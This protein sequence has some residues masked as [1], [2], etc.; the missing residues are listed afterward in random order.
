MLQ[1]RPAH[2][3]A[4]QI[5]AAKRFE[6]ALAAALR[7]RLPGHLHAMGESG[8]SELVA[9]GVARA[10]GW[11]FHDQRAVWYYLRV[12]L[13][14]G[15]HFDRDPQYPWAQAILGGPAA[16]GSRHRAE[17]LYQSA[18]AYWRL[19]AGDDH[20]YLSEAVSFLAGRDAVLCLGTSERLADSQTLPARLATVHWQRYAAQGDRAVLS[21]TESGL[22]QAARWGLRAPLDRAVFVLAQF[23]LGSHFLEDPQYPWTGGLMARVAAGE[24]GM[25]EALYG[26]LVN[27]LSTCYFV[28]VQEQRFL[29]SPKLC[30]LSP[31][32]GEGEGEGAGFDRHLA[33]T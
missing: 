3:E 28:P 5:S 9:L 8:L 10:R 4:F 24:R 23:L 29:S 30:P 6:A 20:A 12:M 22:A 14:L 7:P 31:A 27:H 26:E 13:W 2:R 16:D 1:R 18:L 32:G 11:G 17:R 25:A 19:V 21:L 15:S 33:A